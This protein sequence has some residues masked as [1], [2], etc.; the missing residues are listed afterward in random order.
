M[1]KNLTQLNFLIEGGV[2][3]S[4]REQSDVFAV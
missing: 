2:C 4:R 1:I 3:E